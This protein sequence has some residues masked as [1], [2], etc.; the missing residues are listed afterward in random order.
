MPTDSSIA[1]GTY[2][3]EPNK[4]VPLFSDVGKDIYMFKVGK[5]NWKVR[6]GGR[7]VCL[8]PHGWGQ[9]IE[10]AKS[11][12]VDNEKKILRIGD[13]KFK[14]NSKSRIEDEV[15]KHVRKFKNGEEFLEKGK[16]MI[17]G[18]IVQTLRPIY[19]YCD[20]KKGKVSEVIQ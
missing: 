20:N 16:A 11:V 3:E 1:I 2:V 6:L 7:E 4:I 8:V 19:L 14:I 12:V 5:D 15:D 9:V 13:A 10:N 17:K 18:E